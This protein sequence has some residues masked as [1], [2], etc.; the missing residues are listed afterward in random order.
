[1]QGE[2]IKPRRPDSSR[3]CTADHTSPLT[4][5]AVSPPGFEAL[6]AAELE[7]LVSAGVQAVPGGVTFPGDWPAV[8][9]A[10][11]W[12][13]VASRILVRVTEFEATRFAR[14]AAGFAAVPWGE[15]LPAAC[16]VELRVT[17]RTSRLYH[18]GRVRQEL[19]AVLATA[20]GARAVPAGEEGLRLYVRLERDRA[21]VSL[22]TSGEHLHRRGY[23]DHAGAAPLRENLAAGLLARAHWQ[24]S[25]ALFDPCCGSGTFPVEAARWAMGTAPGAQRTFAFQRLPTFQSEIWQEMLDSAGPA[26]VPAAGI[27]AADRDPAALALAVRSARQAGVADVVQVAAMSLEELEAPGPSGLVIAN[28]P[29]GRR[30]SGASEAYRALGRALRGPLRGWRWAIV[31]AGDAA[32]RALGMTPQIS[33]SFRNGGFAV[34]LLLGGP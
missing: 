24:P 16:A 12:S 20:L 23:R 11:L 4:A 28:P 18:S 1:M 14:L 21:T 34:R 9:R 33:H 30:L 2:G 17:C 3:R 25:E 8:Y 13:R 31:A 26:G 15:W 29:Y 19:A 10:N 32:C 5:F 6:V 7:P 27:Y 22:D